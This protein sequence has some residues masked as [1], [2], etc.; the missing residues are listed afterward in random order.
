[1]A[2]FYNGP[3]LLLLLYPLWFWTILF[4]NLPGFILWK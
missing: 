1:M 4:L 2:A 3:V